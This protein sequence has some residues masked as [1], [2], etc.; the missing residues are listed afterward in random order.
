MRTTGLDAMSD[1]LAVKAVPTFVQKD[2]FAPTLSSGWTWTDLR[3]INYFIN[4][5]VDPNVPADVRNNYMGIAR[6]F[7]AYFYF[8]K[9]KRFGNVPWIGKAT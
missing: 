8:D 6:F 2:A 9:V 5:N 7:R 1:Y 4:N 3:N